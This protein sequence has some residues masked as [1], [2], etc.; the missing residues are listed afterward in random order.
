L[1]RA[2]PCRKSPADYEIAN[3][4][5]I[6]DETL[7]DLTLAQADCRIGSYRRVALLG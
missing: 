4:D 7:G 1:Q 3:I 5:K 2:N 6:F